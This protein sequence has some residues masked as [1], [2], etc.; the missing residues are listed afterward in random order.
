MA[1]TAQPLGSCTEQAIARD[2]AAQYGRGTL[3]YLLDQ[4]PVHRALRIPAEHAASGE[5]RLRSEPLQEHAAEDG[6]S[7]LPSALPYAIQLGKILY[8]PL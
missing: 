3:I 1:P 2:A 4:S 7:F 5:V 6:A 8:S